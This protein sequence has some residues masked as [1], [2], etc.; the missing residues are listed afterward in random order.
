MTLHE[1][2]VPEIAGLDPWCACGFRPTPDRPL[3][4]HLKDKDV[5]TEKGEEVPPTYYGVPI[6]LHIRARSPQEAREVF[7]RVFGD[8][9]GTPD[10]FRDV[11]WDR[12]GIHWYLPLYN[13][14]DDGAPIR[15]LY[16]TPEAESNG[17]EER[18]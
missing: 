9:G 1:A 17:R 14:G 2:V 5:L 15:Y 4:R 18:G 16:P 6:E 8:D 7:E 11:D 13:G 12:H 10:D 3:A